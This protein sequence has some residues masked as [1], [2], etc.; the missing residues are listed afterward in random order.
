MDHLFITTRGRLEG[1][2]HCKEAEFS[3]EDTSRHYW[4]RLSLQWESHVAHGKA[5]MCRSERYKY[6]RRH[7][8][9]DEFYDLLEDPGETINRIDDQTYA[10][11]IAQL[12]ERMLRFFMETSDVVP[13][14]IDRRW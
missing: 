13:H 8:E 1:E 11:T 2:D 10:P 3:P 14:T 4:P 12:R 9:M 5:V 6:V 7:Y